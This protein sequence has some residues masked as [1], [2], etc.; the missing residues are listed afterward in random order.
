VASHSLRLVAHVGMHGVSS[1]RQ[2]WEQQLPSSAAAATTHTHS[3]TARPLC[4]S[5]LN[6]S[7]L[8]KQGAAL[9]TDKFKIRVQ[10]TKPVTWV[11]LIWGA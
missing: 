2:Q 11:P 6:H 8:F 3:A 10:L 7:P 5:L 9:E 4:S 1:C